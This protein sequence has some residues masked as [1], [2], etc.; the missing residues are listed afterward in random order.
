M[1]P[2]ATMSKLMTTSFF[3]FTAPPDC[4]V[5]LDAEVGLFQRVF[6]AGAKLLRM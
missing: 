5:R 2:F 3:T 4:R 1:K 6:A